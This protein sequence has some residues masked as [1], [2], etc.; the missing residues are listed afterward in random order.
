MYLFCVFW[1]DL[2]ISVANRVSGAGNNFYFGVARAMTIN[3]R[4]C[5]PFKR[6]VFG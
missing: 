5:Q 6:A 4:Q 1:R 2:P 3:E